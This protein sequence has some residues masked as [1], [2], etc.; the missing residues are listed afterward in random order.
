MSVVVNVV[1]ETAV[2]VSVAASTGASVSVAASTGASVVASGGIGPAGFLTVPGTSTLA[3]GT[4]QLAAGDGI[5]VSTANGQFLISSYSG[6][7]VSSLAPVQSVAGRTGAVVL[8][9]SDVTAGTFAISRIPTI[10][11]TALSGIPTAFMP[12]SHTHD[13]SDVASGTLSIARIPTISYTALSNTP[14]T[15]SPGVHTHSTTD[16]AAFTAAASAAAP[17]QSVAGR[18]GAISLTTADVAGLAA[19]AT[20]GSYTSLQGV[21][22]TFAPAT[23]T[24]S[25]SNLTQS[26][27]TAGQVPTWNGSAWAPAT[28]SNAG[29]DENAAI[30]GGFFTGPVAITI[31]QQ[32]TN[33]TAASGAA[34]FSVAATVSPSG[35]PTYQW[36]RGVAGAFSVTQRTL[37]AS[38]AWNGVAY[39]N[40]T[41]IAVGG[42]AGATSPD[43]ITWTQRTLPVVANGG[44]WWAVA[45]GGS[46][47]VATSYSRVTAATST[48]GI[49]WTTTTMPQSAI[50]EGIAYGSGVFVALAS[51]SNV[52]AT[53]T[54]GITWTQRTLPASST[55]KSVAFGG[56]TFVAVAYAADSTLA[57]TSTDGITWTQRTLPA[58]GWVAVAY[59]NG[60]FVALASDSAIAATSADGI[61]WTQRTLPVSAGWYSLTFGGGTF[62]ATTFVGTIAATSTDGITWTQRTLPSNPDWWGVAYGDGKFV[63]VEYTSSRAVTIQ[64]DGQAAFDIIAGATSASLA[65]TSLTAGNNADQYRALVSATNAQSV[66]SNAATLTVT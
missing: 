56:G 18:S 59:G 33:Q 19:I 12:A 63:A 64:L 2:S 54:D 44:S 23:H 27:A 20:S 5:T 3:F 57:A 41:F 1:G 36:Q 32:P 26:S 35:S 38:A 45:F 55:W 7:A 22:A 25:L 47:F 24:H 53:S 62:L 31:T 16:V 40:G 52:A 42:S 10:G 21:P 58:A 60:V 50:W 14:T 6:T 29:L 11:Y 4:F 30:D 9:A 43:G 37:P 66:L 17:V 15:F 61:T 49:N 65:L 8:Q 34:T 48:D 46:R 28:P 13:A 39:G 51:G